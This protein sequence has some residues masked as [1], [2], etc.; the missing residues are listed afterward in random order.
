MGRVIRV[1]PGRVTVEP[2]LT[3]PRGYLPSRM[4]YSVSSSLS[5]ISCVVPTT[6]RPLPDGSECVNACPHLGRRVPK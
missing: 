4:F 2:P 5:N 3:L 6:F 1:G